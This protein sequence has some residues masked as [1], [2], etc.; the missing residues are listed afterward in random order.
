[1]NKYIDNIYSYKNALATLTRV[2]I[3]KT[4]S[5]SRLG[6]L[7]WL[8]D[9]L[10]LMLIYYFMVKVIFQRGGENYHLF[11][12]CGIIIWQSFA[13]IINTN[14]KA[15]LSNRGLIRQVVI[16]Y[17]ILL[18]VPAFVQ[19]FFIMIGA[20]IVM[21]LNH[22]NIGMHSLAVIPLTILVGLFGTAL[23]LFLS[24][25]QVYIR[26]TAEFVRYAV[27]A[28]F[29][30]SPVLYPPS[31]VMES[32]AIPAFVKTIYTLNPM[33]WIIT[34]YRDVLLYGQLFEWSGYFNVLLYTLV[35][36]QGGL[37]WLRS[38]SSRVIKSL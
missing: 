37:W 17:E 14:T 25:F 31:R 8:I 16:P 22:Q 24:V 5:S 27:R 19:V 11:I 3:K 32:D 33:V 1:M 26:D 4:V 6:W 7:W 20:I 38:Q 2:N 18:S 21:L 12:L 28:G 10:I 23:G 9:P 13:R 30:L 36:L 34:A 15:L 29:F 35:I